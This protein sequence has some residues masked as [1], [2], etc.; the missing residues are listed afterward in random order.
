MLVCVV[1]EQLIEDINITDFVRSQCID[2]CTCHCH[3]VNRS[4]ANKHGAKHSFFFSGF[5][6]IFNFFLFLFFYSY[7]ISIDSNAF[8]QNN[9]KNYLARKSNGENIECAECNLGEVKLEPIQSAA[10]RGKPY[11]GG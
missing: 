7:W 6:F 10:V 3:T 8:P 2:L 1:P 11:A 5:F 9:S 4:K